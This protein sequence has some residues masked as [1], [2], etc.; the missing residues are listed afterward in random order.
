[1]A[2]H[3]LSCCLGGGNLSSFWGKN[4]AQTGRGLGLPVGPVIGVN[5]VHENL[6]DGT[7]PDSVFV[8]FPTTKSH[9][10]ST[11][12]CVPPAKESCCHSASNNWCF[13]L[14]SLSVAV[15]RCVAICHFLRVFV[16]LFTLCV[17]SLARCLPRFLPVFIE[18]VCFWIIE[19]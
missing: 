2:S 9:F 5:L 18:I 19:F 10:P 15:S 7:L 6:P 17:S 1:M 4:T 3:W 14:F 13:F 16:C 8:R 11:C 12:T